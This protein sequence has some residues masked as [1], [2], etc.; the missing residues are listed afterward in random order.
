MTLLEGV[1]SLRSLDALWDG[2][3]S[4]LGAL[5]GETSSFDVI[6]GVCQG[7]PISPTLFIDFIDWI[8]RRELKDVPGVQ[9]SSIKSITGLAYADGIA[10]L[11]DSFVAVQEALAGVERYAV[12]KEGVFYKQCMF[13]S[14]LCNTCLA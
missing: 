4:T 8:L 12:L 10:L 7:C 2:I 5:R 3:I 11:G 14:D 6:S 1:V 13:R 9:L